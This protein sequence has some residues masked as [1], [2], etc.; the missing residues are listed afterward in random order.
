M[1]PATYHP[2]MKVGFAG[3]IPNAVAEKESIVSEAAWATGIAFVAHRGRRR[4]VLPLA[5]VAHRHRASRRFSASGVAYA[6]AY[7]WF[8]YVN[9]TGM[10]LG[11][12]IL[13]NGINYPIV[14]LS[15]YREFR[16]RGQAPADARREAVQN[17]LRA[18]LVGACVA[19]IAYGSLSITQFRGFSQFGWIGF[20][21]M[22]L[23]WLSMIPCV[24]ALIVVI[25]RIQAAAAAR[26]CAIPRR[27]SA[28]TEAR[29]TGDAHRRPRDGPSAVGV[30]RRGLGAHGGRRLEDPRLPA[31]SLGV[32]LRPPRLAREQA[33]RGGA[34]GR[35]RPRRS[36][37]AR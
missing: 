3:D 15:R 14:L 13:G 33:R 27:G 1:K 20:V 22:L 37:A 5:V 30:R 19:S 21:G 12:I 23:V 29:R 7:F 17:A 2:E 36:S 34:S 11:A 25:E 8:G 4:L 10:F 24:P 6:F 9:T 35:T 18:E 32:R 26:G 28:P 16:A 31:R